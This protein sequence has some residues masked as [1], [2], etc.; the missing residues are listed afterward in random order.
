MP[1]IIVEIKAPNKL[2]NYNLVSLSKLFEATFSTIIEHKRPRWLSPEKWVPRRVPS[3][4]SSL[5][6]KMTVIVGY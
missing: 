5:A 3:E 4:H 2:G 6:Q 1:S